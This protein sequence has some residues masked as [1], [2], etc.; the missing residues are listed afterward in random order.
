M[1]ICVALEA[2]SF[3]FKREIDRKFIVLL[4]SER[5][6]RDY[7]GGNSVGTTMV[8]LNQGILENMPIPA[9]PLVDAL[10]SQCAVA[11]LAAAVA[12]MT[13]GT[14]RHADTGANG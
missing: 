1:A 11:L 13:N 10:E 14:E 2:S 12:E 8:N 6:T 4:F 7:L 5:H 9:P 3:V